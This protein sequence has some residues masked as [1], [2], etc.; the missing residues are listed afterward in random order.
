MGIG[1]MSLQWCS[2]AFKNPSFLV[3]Q[4]DIMIRYY[5]TPM[6]IV[7]LPRCRLHPSKSDPVDNRAVDGGP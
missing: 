5:D 1:Y 6:I 7:R 2:T 4:Y 3:I